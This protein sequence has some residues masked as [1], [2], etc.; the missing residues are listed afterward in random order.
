VPAEFHHTREGRLGKRGTKGIP[1]CPQHHRIG[2][3]ALHVMGKRAWERKFGITE[4]QLQEE[5]DKHG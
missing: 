1:L 4:H 2:P 3:D 5:C